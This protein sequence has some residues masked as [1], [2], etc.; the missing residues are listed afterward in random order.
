MGWPQNPCPAT[1]GVS[2]LAVVSSF[3]TLSPRDGERD[4][5]SHRRDRRDALHSKCDRL[6]RNGVAPERLDP[7]LKARLRLEN[8][9][10]PVFEAEGSFQVELRDAEPGDDVAAAMA[11]PL[12]LVMI[13][14]EGMYAFE[15]L[16]A[17]DQMGSVRFRAH[18]TV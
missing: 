11:F 8:R 10:E 6:S 15:I 12:H 13:P 5:G 16:V 3:W 4:V 7:G 17:G 14:S 2:S 1:A 18:S 9:D